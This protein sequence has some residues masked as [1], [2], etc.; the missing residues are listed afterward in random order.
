M[1]RRF[2]SLFLAA[3]MVL[4]VFA[5]ADGAVTGA[6]QARAAVDE[7]AEKADELDGEWIGAWGSGMT[8]ISFADYEDL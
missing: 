8:N 7:N 5:V 2:L 3:L 4:S 1:K 6:P